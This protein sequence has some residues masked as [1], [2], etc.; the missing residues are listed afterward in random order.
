MLLGWRILQFLAALQQNNF[1]LY[2]FNKFL[3]NLGNR[4]IIIIK[5]AEA[6][7]QEALL[8]VRLLNLSNFDLLILS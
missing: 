3:G 1:L 8:L 7:S 5:W 6:F 4:C 2:L